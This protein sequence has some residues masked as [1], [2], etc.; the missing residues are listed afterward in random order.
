M[1]SGAEAPSVRIGDV[2]AKAATHKAPC[3]GEMRG[4]NVLPTQLDDIAGVA[5]HIVLGISRYAYFISRY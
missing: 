5:G 4:E 3:E 1:T 2:A